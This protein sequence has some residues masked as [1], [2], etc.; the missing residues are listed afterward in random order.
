MIICSICGGTHVSCA[1][2]VDPNTK[3]FVDF[4]NEAFLDGQCKQCGNVTLVDPDEIKSDIDKKWE[5][6][7]S[8]HQISP[9]YAFCGVVRSGSDAGN[10]G[11][12]I[13]V[14]GQENVIERYEVI[15]VC[16]DLEEL[17]AL[18][19]PNMK[20]G[21]ILVECR[22]L[23]FIDTMENKAYE[24]EVDGKVISVTTKEIMDFYSQQYDLTES[25][26]KGYAA[27]HVAKIKCYRECNQLL[28]VTL[29]RRLL[30]EEHLREVGEVDSF[31]LKLYYDWY[32]R[33]RKE[34]ESLYAPFKYAVD[35]YCLDNIQTFSRRYTSMNDDAKVSNRYQTI[36]QYFVKQLE[37]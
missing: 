27:N 20:R 2:I 34:D 13:R 8:L 16:R 10:E 1:A 21:F 11:V 6:Y 19:E 5:Q 29:V 26:I 12:Y 22:Y 36:E 15:A 31:R 23:S 9:N 18:A 25:E 35:A 17:K 33:I 4:G 28:D 14:G 3:S 7:S 24:V 30:E 32:V 37:S